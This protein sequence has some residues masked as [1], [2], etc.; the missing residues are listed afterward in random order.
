MKQFFAILLLLS[1]PVILSAQKMLVLSD[2][3]H[4]FWE[5]IAATCSVPVQWEKSVEELGETAT[6]DK[7]SYVY[8]IDCQQGIALNTSSGEAKALSTAEFSSLFDYDFANPY[9]AEYLE[10]QRDGMTVKAT[11]KA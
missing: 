1:S 5:Q 10:L 6:T 7:E 8:T 3:Q 4:M 9:L 11:L 2:Y